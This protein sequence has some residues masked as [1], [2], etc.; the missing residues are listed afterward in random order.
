VVDGIRRACDEWESGAIDPATL[1]RRLIEQTAKADVSVK[2]RQDAA[3]WCQQLV[4]AW[5]W[6]E[7]GDRRGLGRAEGIVCA[8]RQWASELRQTAESTSTPDVRNLQRKWR[9]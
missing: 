6:A 9:Q 8:L 7:S 2:T 3:G 4:A 1:G 5:E